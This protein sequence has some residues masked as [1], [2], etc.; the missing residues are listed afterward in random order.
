VSE[1]ERCARCGRAVNLPIRVPGG[2]V[3]SNCRAVLAAECCAGCGEVRRVGGRDADRRPWCERCRQR[4]RAD[5][6]DRDRRA[7]IID[8]VTVAI[9]SLTVETIEAALAATIGRRRSLRLLAE[10]LEAHPDALTAGPTS[11]LGVLDRFVVALADAGAPISAI[12]PACERC[13]QRRR[14]HARTPGG[15]QCAGCWAR[16]HREPCSDCGGQRNV[17]HRDDRG[18]PICY[19]CAE[20][21]KRRSRLGELTAEIVAVVL[22]SQPDAP[23]ASISAAVERLTPDGRDR[24]RLARLVRLAADLAVP[25]RRQERVARLLNALRAAG[26]DL[27]AAVC[28]DCDRPAEPLVVYR[29]VARCEPCARRCPGC[30]RAAKGPTEPW[31]RRCE[32]DPRRGACRACSAERVLLDDSGRCR[33]CRER[34]ERRC[35]RCDATGPRTW[36][37]ESWLCHRCALAAE[38]DTV[39]GPAEALPTALIPLRAAVVSADNW[40][41]VSAW[42]R[43][44]AGGQMLARLAAGH[45][46]ISHETLDD[47]HGNK[48]VEHLR[49]LLVATGALPEVADRRVDRLEAFLQSLL[50]DT[51]VDPADAKVVRAFL[52][53]QVLPRLR[54]QAETGA[55]M[56][57]SL[58]RVRGDLRVVIALAETLHREQRSLATITQVDLDRWFAQPGHQVWRARPFLVWA[59][60]RRHLPQPV[61]VAATP[62][63]VIRSPLHDEQRWVIA[64]RLVADDTIDADDRVAAALLVLYGQP[65]TRIARLRTNDVRLGADGAAVVVLDGTP[66]PIHEPFATLIGQL[67]LRRSNGVSDQLTGSWL[68]PGR[69]AGQPVGPL[70]LANRMRAMGIEPRDMRNTARAQLAGSIPAAMLGEII[71]ISP[72]TATRWTAIANGNWA[73]YAARRAR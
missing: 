7:V 32:D 43:D 58:N 36:M 62:P 17:D 41:R 26:I 70:I 10:H 19:R 9:P 27:P 28:E 2:R 6:F 69:S 23:P 3:C 59:K 63:K 8:A 16:T 25:S 4:S 38:F 45:V 5:Q 68:F 49:A 48:S 73:A 71:G 14:W 37:C 39:I 21:A 72:G 15:G 57:A 33:T 47:A 24:V 65:L 67:P 51:E 29:Q 53:W 54:R 11:T 44:S 35:A 56:T 31:C 22:A 61:T 30:G 20:A 66:M 12:H 52:R 42:L 46:P 60:A 40:T 1:T 13:G 50:S 55:S 18:R 64:R 34:T